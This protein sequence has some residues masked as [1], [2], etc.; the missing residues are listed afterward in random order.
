M[1]ADFNSDWTFIY[2]CL[3]KIPKKINFKPFEGEIMEWKTEKG[4]LK[5]KKVKMYL[6]S[7]F[8]ASLFFHYIYKLA[9]FRIQFS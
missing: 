6:Y 7:L 3:H 1:K 9:Y 2:F 4:K 5:E 8:S